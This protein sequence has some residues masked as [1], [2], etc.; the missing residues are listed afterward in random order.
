MDFLRS[1]AHVHNCNAERARTTSLCRPDS[2][3]GARFH[4]RVDY[5]IGNFAVPWSEH[6][7]Y[8]DARTPSISRST[9]DDLAASMGH[10]PAHLPGDGIVQIDVVML[11]YFRADAELGTYVASYALMTMAMSFVPILGQVFM[12]LL[13]ET[14]GKGHN[15]QKKYLRWFGN[16]TV[17]L[18]L[19]IAVGG[20][21]LAV[22]LTQFVFGS[23]YSE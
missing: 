11:K 19:P 17:G 20:F 1:L 15:A 22:P 4:G 8:L 5:S 10:L 9:A 21:I 23:Q 2:R 16:A 7:T 3:P 6:A 14:A 12:P 18:A 13:S